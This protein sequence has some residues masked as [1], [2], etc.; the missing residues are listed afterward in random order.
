MKGRST[1]SVNINNNVCKYKYVLYMYIFYIYPVLHIFFI[2]NLFS[3]KQHYY[4]LLFY[5]FLHTKY[6]Y[7]LGSYTIDLETVVLQIELTM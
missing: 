2:Y 1:M 4:S 5:D 3:L 7:S 6:V